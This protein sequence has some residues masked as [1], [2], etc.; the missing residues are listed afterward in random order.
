M[1]FPGLSEEMGKDLVHCPAC[2]WDIMRR[3]GEYKRGI[4]TWGDGLVRIV[5][6]ICPEFGSSE[7]VFQKDTVRVALGKQR[8]FCLG[9]WGQL[10]ACLA[11]FGG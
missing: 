10:I 4:G 3:G 2:L 11:C 8:P 9:P 6:A 1:A 5:L 7:P